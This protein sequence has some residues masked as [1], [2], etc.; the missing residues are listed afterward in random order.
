MC[1]NLLTATRIGL[2]VLNA[3]PGSFRT[4]RFKQRV[5]FAMPA[6]T[7]L[8]VNVLLLFGYLIDEYHT[9]PTALFS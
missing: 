2:N 8:T 7:S 6:S 1:S 4:F 9:D 5:K 3:Q